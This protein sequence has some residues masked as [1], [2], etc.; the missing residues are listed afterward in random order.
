M[1]LLQF[2]RL[3]CGMCTCGKKDVYGQATA[4]VKSGRTYGETNCHFFLQEIIVVKATWNIK[5]GRWCLE[6]QCA[7]RT[8]KHF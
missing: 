5:Y 8:P 3:L 4:G 6:R 1:L 7:K 2:N